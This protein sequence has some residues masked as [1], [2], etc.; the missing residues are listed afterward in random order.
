MFGF[1]GWSAKVNLYQYIYYKRCNC[2]IEKRN[3]FKYVYFAPHL[4]KPRNIVV[5]KRIWKR[6]HL[7]LSSTVEKD[8]MIFRSR[9]LLEESVESESLLKEFLQSCPQRILC[10]SISRQHTQVLK[11]QVIQA[12]L[13][14]IRFFHFQIVPVINLK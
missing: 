14:S 8:F 2:A 13:P 1:I 12:K 4:K 6:C 10:N 11:G 7:T 5:S 3:S 9:E